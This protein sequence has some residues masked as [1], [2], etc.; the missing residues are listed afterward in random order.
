[1]ELLLTPSGEP[2]IWAGGERGGLVVHR[3]AELLL[4]FDEVMRWWELRQRARDLEDLAQ[5]AVAFCVEARQCG[6]LVGTA[7]QDGIQ[8]AGEQVGIAERIADAVA[9]DR[10]AVVAGITHQGPAGTDRLADLVRHADHPADRRRASGVGGD[11][12][13]QLRCSGAQH[14][15]ERGI[16]GVVRA[17]EA[18]GVVC[19][20]ADP[21]ARLAVVR[22]KD[23]GE[24]PLA[25]VVLH[26]RPITRVVGVVRSATG[27]AQF[28]ERSVD[29]ASDARSQPVGADDEP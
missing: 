23:T 17:A 10:V 3:C 2:R 8:R 9:R 6:G 5:L 16:D 11:P 28:G 7:A 24:Q 12:I 20:R 29:G 26:R 19:R 13:G 1:M 4:Q 25:E 21:D 27:A 14:R 22:R 15:V 18:Q